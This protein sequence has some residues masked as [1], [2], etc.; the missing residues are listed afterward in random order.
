MLDLS[1]LPHALDYRSGNWRLVTGSLS[2]HD[3][4]LRKW[5]HSPGLEKK[6]QGWTVS[7][8]R[9]IGSLLHSS[10]ISWKEKAAARWKLIHGSCFLSL[11]GCSLPD[12][13]ARRK[14]C[15]KAHDWRLKTASDSRVHGQPSTSLANRSSTLM[16]VLY[17]PSARKKKKSALGK[18]D[19]WI[20]RLLPGE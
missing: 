13:E 20:K 4:S 11:P 3:K 16:P 2:F 1:F 12:K 14:E 5:N 7:Q 8:S 17:L 19:H 10:N 6:I 9:E 18:E 15:W